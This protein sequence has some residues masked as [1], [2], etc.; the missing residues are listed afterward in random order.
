[1]STVPVIECRTADDV[2]ALYARVYQRK[3]GLSAPR[4]QV[5]TLLPKRQPKPEPVKVVEPEPEPTPEPEV[6]FDL[7]PWLAKPVEDGPEEYYSCFVASEQPK[8]SLIIRIVAQAF[9]TT[10]TDIKSDRRMATI[11]APRQIVAWLARTLTRH[12]LP[13]IGKQIGGR[14]HTTILHACRRVEAKRAAATEYLVLTDQL[15]A[16]IEVEHASISSGAKHVV[17]AVG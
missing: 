16:E 13:T 2:R 11:I 9:S 4:V 6:A 1:M 14:D 8:I 3:R 15:R 5:V 17:R 10:A 7:R 12:S